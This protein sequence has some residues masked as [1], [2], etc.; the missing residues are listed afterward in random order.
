[1]AALQPFFSVIIPTLNEEKY[2]PKLLTCLSLQIDKD[3]D[4][5]VVDAKSQDKTVQV[6]TKFKS[7][8]KNIAVVTS[9]IRSPGPQRNLGAAKAAGKFLVFMDADVT[10]PSNYLSEIHHYLTTTN[11]KC[12]FLSTWQKPDSK[13]S[14]DKFIANIA[15]IGMEL[16]KDSSK[17]LVGGMVMII[18]RT[19]F[20]KVHG[21]DEKVKLAEDYDLAQRLYNA[22]IKL[23]I[24]KNPKITVSFRRVRREGTFSIIKKQAL[25]LAKIAFEG[26]ITELTYDYPMG[27]AV[28]C[29]RRKSHSKLKASFKQFLNYLSSDIKLWH[30][31]Q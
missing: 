2:L 6:A 11:P 26:P 31:G 28:P 23:H 19:A 16:A 14:S 4:V 10:L 15:S 29:H 8:L 9:P 20:F 1:M 25:A 3:F 13:R 7:Q 21:F 12:Q 24:L 17:P 30:L 18:K 27:G 22:N 5:T